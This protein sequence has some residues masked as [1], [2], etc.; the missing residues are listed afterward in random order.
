[1]IWEDKKKLK[2]YFQQWKDQV[3][4]KTVLKIEYPFCWKFWNCEIIFIL[5]QNGKLKT[6]VIRCQGLRNYFSE[7]KEFQSFWLETLAGS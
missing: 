7:E 5:L 2:I 1:M 3:Q 6:E 4:T